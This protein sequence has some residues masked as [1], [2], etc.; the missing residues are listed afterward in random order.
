VVVGDEQPAAT[1]KA[2]TMTSDA[3]ADTPR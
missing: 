1:A 2:R 3:A